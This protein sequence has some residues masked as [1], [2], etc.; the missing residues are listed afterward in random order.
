VGGCMGRGGDA[1]TRISAV[2]AS[3]LDDC[4]AKKKPVDSRDVGGDNVRNCSDHICCM[5]EQSCGVI[6]LEEPMSAWRF[7]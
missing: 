3:L 6:L 7:M 1:G 4:L 5:Y 2:V